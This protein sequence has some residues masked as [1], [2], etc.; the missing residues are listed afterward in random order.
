[1][2]SFLGWEKQAGEGYKVL[3][4]Y[5]RSF[6]LLTSTIDTPR[7]CICCLVFRKNICSFPINYATSKS[8]LFRRRLSCLI[9]VTVFFLCW[10]SFH[11]LRKASNL[12][13]VTNALVQSVWSPIHHLLSPSFTTD[14][15]L[16]EYI[17]CMPATVSSVP[18]LS[19][20]CL[21]FPLSLHFHLC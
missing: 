14:Y 19:S 13:C 18:Q 7:C 21:S 20:R 1:M 17:L 6:S 3:E 8:D 16:F 11:F 4:R 12:L 5:Q 15:V 2:I 10:L 9:S